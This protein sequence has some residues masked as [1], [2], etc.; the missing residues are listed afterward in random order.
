MR[1]A[2]HSFEVRVHPWF[3]VASNHIFV[4]RQGSRAWIKKSFFN[5]SM[6]AE[7][8]RVF[9]GDKQ[10]TLFVLSP[11]QAARRHEATMPANLTIRPGGG[12]HG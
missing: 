11:G 3:S 5:L 10:A 9:E 1:N 2:V 7:Q 12:P 8:Y 6:E 4:G